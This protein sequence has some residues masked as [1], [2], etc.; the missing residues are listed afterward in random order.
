[1][2]N[3][4]CAATLTRRSR[5][6]G[7]CCGMSQKPP[8]Q[9]VRDFLAAFYA[10]DIAGALQRCDDDIDL[11]ANAPVELF[12]HFG[13]RRGKAEVADTWR[14][15]HRLFASMRYEVPFLVAD[16]E[17]AAA[18]IKIYFRKSVSDRVV[19]TSIAD[20]Y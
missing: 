2:R 6:T 20:F 19:Q 7:T 16:D 18:V 15:L 11:L 4:A 14:A 1:M 5:I 9:D 17:R 3:A 8:G 10:G 13:P 12:P